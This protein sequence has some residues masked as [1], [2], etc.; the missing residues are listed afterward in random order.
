MTLWKVGAGAGLVLVLALGMAACGDTAGTEALSGLTQA[1]RQP[2]PDGGVCE[3]AKECLVIEAGK[4]ISHA[5]LDFECDPGDFDVVV[6]T[7]HF[8]PRVVTD[9]LKTDG[10]PCQDLAR[11]YRFEVQGPDRVAKVCVIFYE[12]RSEV[13]IGSKAADACAFE[14]TLFPGEDCD[15]CDDGEGGHGGYGGDGGNGYGGHGG[16]PGCGGDGGNGYGGHGGCPGCGGDGG[17]GY[18]G[19]GGG[20]GAGPLLL[21]A[22]P[23]GEPEPAN[24]RPLRRHGRDDYLNYP[25]RGPM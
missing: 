7:E 13:R 23:R 15:P 12:E 9:R 24:R 4:N 25:N 2:P 3:E 10:G 21:R 18:G 1:H 16:C 17:N 22:A 19:E 8:G 6:V 5:F 20:G 14:G 11:D